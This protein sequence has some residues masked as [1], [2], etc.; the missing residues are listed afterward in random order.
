MSF[1]LSLLIPKRKVNIT[2]KDADGKDQEVTF[3]VRGLNVTDLT[4]LLT[5]H[6]ESLGEIFAQ[7]QDN[8]NF[9][10]LELQA[11]LG[12]ILI[13]LPDLI[14]EIVFVTSDMEMPSEFFLQLPLKNQLDFITAITSVTLEANGGIKKLQEIV[15]NLAL[16]LKESQKELSQD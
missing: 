16:K 5:D 10:D 15:L 6:S 3:L 14:S 12:K 8:G 11:L 2:Y 13:D 1:D 9:S 7:I 4:R